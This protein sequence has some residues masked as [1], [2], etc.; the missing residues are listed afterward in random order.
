MATT[1]SSWNELQD[2]LFGDCWNPSLQR[3]RSQE[4]FRGL[5]DAT[6]PLK[7]S[8]IRLGGPFSTLEHHLLR[9]FKKYAHR[10]VVEADSFWHWLS[11]A[12][13][14]G[15]PT[16]LLDWTYSPY[17]ALHFATANTT[18]CDVDGVI[19]AVNYAKVHDLLPDV[20]KSLLRDEG[21]DV[22]T[23][24]MLHQ[25]ADSFRNFAALSTTP[26]VTFFEPPSIADRIVNQSAL[27]SVASIPDLVLD[28]W[29]AN[30]PGLWRKIVI[31]STLK[32][33]VRDKLDQAK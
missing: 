23:V 9:N 24:D 27:F 15:L 28:A 33:E 2:L 22:F 19:W 32:W 13:H 11:V 20:L 29:L 1:E 21:S 8:L 6:Y 3:H 26:F 18:K 14:H 25:A 4:A 5:S 30:H 16:R 17:V 10:D 7:T 12:Q 31:P